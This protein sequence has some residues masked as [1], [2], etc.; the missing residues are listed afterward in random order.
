MEL[1]AAERHGAEDG[2]VSPVVTSRKVVLRTA[3]WASALDA[4]QRGTVVICPGR[5]E[6]IEKYYEVVADLRRRGFSVLVL[7]WRGQGLSDRQLRDRRKGHIWTFA[8]FEDD[9]EAVHRQVLEPFCP[10][11]WFALAHSMGAPIVLS[12]AARHPEIFRRIVLSAPMIDIAG[13]PMPNLARVLARW[14]CRIGIG[15][16]FVP[17][18]RNR[19]LFLN[20][21]PGNVLTSDEVRFTRVTSLLE[22]APR[23]S[24]G[25]P[26]YGW[27]NAAFDCI[28]S[29]QQE[30]FGRDFMTP[31]LVVMPGADVVVDCRAAER[32]AGRLRTGTLVTVFGAKHEILM[33]RDS[34]REQFWSAFDAFVPGSS[35]A[36]D[37]TAVPDLRSFAEASVL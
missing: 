37:G 26:T 15:R 33:E 12:F 22:A 34:L 2:I 21:F 31:T 30:R 36:A 10:R 5:S 14:A 4:G 24:I 8:E 7:D 35:S 1:I 17:L 3:R 19:S 18:G 13:L 28:A 11:P 25:P 29:L 27:L 9:L 20:T 23:L 6:F 16:H 32:L